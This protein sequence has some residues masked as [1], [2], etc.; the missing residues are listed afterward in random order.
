M[1]QIIIFA[2]G[3]VTGC[4]LTLLILMYSRSSA[5]EEEEVETE[6]DVSNEGTDKYGN[7]HK[8]FN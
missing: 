3:L 5:P 6:V 8:F 2:A 7:Y 4:A 1:K